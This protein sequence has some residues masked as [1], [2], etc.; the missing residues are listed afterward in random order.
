MV[1]KTATTS[2][3]SSSSALS[4]VLP[5][6]AKMTE[7]MK[8]RFVALLRK[9]HVNT[10]TDPHAIALVDFLL[11][12]IKTKRDYEN[13]LGSEEAA[14]AFCTKHKLPMEQHQIF[15]SMQVRTKNPTEIIRS[16]T[17]DHRVFLLSLSIVLSFFITPCFS[18][19]VY[20]VRFLSSAFSLNVV[21]VPPSLPPN[22]RRCR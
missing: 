1:S 17:S 15:L 13:A 20:F 2:S 11:P 6:S 14:E 5:S 16:F 7:G 21:Y 18:S 9:A 12:I 8:K 10:D 22:Q 19:Y 3:S 4:K